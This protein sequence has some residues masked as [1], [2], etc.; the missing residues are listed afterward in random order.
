LQRSN[1][2]GLTLSFSCLNPANRGAASLSLQFSSDMGLA[3]WDTN[4]VAIPAT[5]VTDLSSGV[6]FVITPSGNL[7]QVSATIP[8]SVA[9]G[10]GKIFG[11]LKALPTR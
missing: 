2:G 7:D 9:N 11:R 1:D 6:V 10:N 5:S 3:E 4:T 8:A